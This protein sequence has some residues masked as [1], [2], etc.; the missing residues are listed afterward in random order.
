[1]ANKEHFDLFMQGA[2]VWNKWRAS[3]DPRLGGDG[4]VIFP[5]LSGVDFS[6]HYDDFDL[7]SYNFVETNLS[8]TYLCKADLYEAYLWGANLSEANLSKANLSQANL[9]G[10]QLS[11]AILNEAILNEADLIEAD[12]TEAELVR[13]QAL[14]TNFEKATFTRACIEDWN[15]NSA[16][17]LNGVVCDYIYL[18][19]GE[20]V[21]P[22]VNPQE[23]RPSIGNFALGEF[24]KLFQKA[25]ETVDLIFLNGIDWQAFL[26]SFQQLHVEAGDKVLSIQAIENKNDG[27]FVIRVSVPPELDKAKIENYFKQKYQIALKTRDEQYRKHLRERLRDKDELIAISREAMTSVR[28]DNTQLIGIINTMAEKENS[29]YYFHQPQIGNFIDT[30]QDGSRQQSINHQHNYPL[31]QKQTL[32]E[33]ASEIQ[34]LL[35]QLEQT[36]P[37]ATEAEKMAYVTASVPLTLKARTVS[38]LKAG[39]KEVLKELLDNPY[40]NIGVA[41]VE[42]W[43]SPE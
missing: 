9:I 39:G 28:Q 20:G 16:T 13:T 37:A 4:I 23:R 15:I 32:A 43:Q 25:R 1:M 19:A 35:R 8:R 2:E 33:A 29:K 31:E 22:L 36:K 30:A 17:N 26:V 10:T 3:R 27:A 5:D 42:G 7:S 41:I 21:L 6:G 12:L 14:G 40:V 38:A 18:K 24:T 34:Q 11:K